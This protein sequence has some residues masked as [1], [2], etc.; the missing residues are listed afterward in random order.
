VAD[1]G[2]PAGSVG[3]HRVATTPPIG[4]FRAV[5]GLAHPERLARR[6]ASGSPLYLM[7][8]ARCGAPGDEPAAGLRSGSP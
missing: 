8:G 4:G 1:R 5:V 6:R 2:E 7:D 3:H